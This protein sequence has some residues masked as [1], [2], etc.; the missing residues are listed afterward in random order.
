MNAI[1]LVV[2]DK[3]VSFWCDDYTT[4]EEQ[5]TA[6]AAFIAAVALLNSRRA[7]FDDALVA[8]IKEINAIVITGSDKTNLGATGKYSMLLSSA[9]IALCSIAWIASLFIHEGQH[10]LNAGKYPAPN[11]WC[12]EQSAARMQLTAG[13]LMGFTPSE[14]ADL[15][16]YSADSN[17]SAMEVHMRGYKGPQ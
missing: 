10:H 7:Y 16:A 1:Q 14:G 17:A 8:A 2:F 6:T 4:P 3:P 5:A 15:I 13:V 11:E 12:N 9:Y